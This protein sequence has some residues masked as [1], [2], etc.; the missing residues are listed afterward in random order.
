MEIGDGPT[1]GV[2]LCRD[3][4]L[5]FTAIA[6]DFLLIEDRERMIREYKARSA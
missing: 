4:A 3:C 6:L 5:E 1:V 2:A